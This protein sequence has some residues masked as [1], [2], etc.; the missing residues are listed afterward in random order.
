MSL[1]N[2]DSLNNMQ[3]TLKGTDL[4]EFYQFLKKYETELP[5]GLQLL[6]YNLEKDM[7][8]YLTISE[9]ESLSGEGNTSRKG[10][11]N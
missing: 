11:K 4:I 5:K 10:E 8:N 7:Y 1:L 9:M 6:L 3:L 2:Y